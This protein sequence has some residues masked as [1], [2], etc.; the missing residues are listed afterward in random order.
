MV[1]NNPKQLKNQYLAVF[2]AARLEKSLV[3]LGVV[4]FLL[5]PIAFSV[6]LN[7]SVVWP[8]SLAG[9]TN[10]SAAAAFSFWLEKK[11]FAAMLGRS[12][13]LGL[14]ASFLSYFLAK[15]IFF[16]WLFEKRLSQ[17]Y[18]SQSLKLRRKL[19]QVFFLLILA[20]PYLSLALATKSLFMERGWFWRL[21]ASLTGLDGSALSADAFPLAFGVLTLSLKQTFFFL[22]LFHSKW[23]AW[24][25]NYAKQA[26]SL[27]YRSSA[28]Y[29][30]IFL[31]LLYPH[32]RFPFLIVL[33]YSLFSVEVP[34][35]FLHSTSPS[36]SL[37]LL[38]LFYHP[39]NLDLLPY[40]LSGGCLLL[41][42]FF[43]LV[44]GLYLL[45]KIYLQVRAY[46]RYQGSQ[47]FLGQVAAGFR[48]RF[49]LR[50]SKTLLGLVLGCWLLVVWM[51]L[52]DSFFVRA[53]YP[54]LGLSLAWDELGAGHPIFTP[55]L[56][57]LLLGFTS[58]L[59]A[60]VCSLYL[61]ER[62]GFRLDPVLRPAT[63][64]LLVLPE[65]SF[66]LSFKVLGDLFLPDVVWLTLLLGHLFYVFSYVYLLLQEQEKLYDPRYSFVGLSLGKSARLVYWKIKLPIVE[67]SLRAA[68]AIG[69]SVSFSLYITT[70]FLTSG[71]VPTL[72]TETLA[73]ISSYQLRQA[74]L[75][76]GILSLA[77]FLMFLLCA[78][79]LFVWKD[80][81][82]A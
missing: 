20:M 73:I 27:G 11:N 33:A 70:L 34:L 49:H 26:F 77:P 39:S 2:R 76:A 82:P 13:V 32:L 35:L 31:P 67:K 16:G 63:L 59:L 43:S 22:Y 51:L 5:V 1:P 23:H 68:F 18:S 52:Q 40:F 25:Q 46:L 81:E 47:A 14:G 8:F 62:P 61:L 79:S 72:V 10:L 15:Q 71:R 9:T 69:F 44:L 42:L 30:E 37:A 29:Q 21:F 58:S 3:W 75:Y 45:E 50:F 78:P 55:L 48:E 38:D 36:L 28:V 24:Y 19:R 74:A 65:I 66:I 41:A 56:N 6:L 64:F 60:C 54:S 7:F 53:P 17:A 80:N 57:S 12:L 4:V